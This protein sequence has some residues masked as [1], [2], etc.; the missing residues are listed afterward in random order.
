MS[1]LFVYGIDENSPREAIAEF[2]QFGQ[3][4]ELYS[5]RAR[6]E[7]SDPENSSFLHE[8]NLSHQIDFWLPHMGHKWEIWVVWDICT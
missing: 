7:S 8:M 4:T 6:K 2:E 5:P 3:V 1:E